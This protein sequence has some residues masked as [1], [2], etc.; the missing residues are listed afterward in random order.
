MSSAS[1]LLLVVSGSLFWASG[2]CTSSNPLQS[3]CS[4][5]A[6]CA[7]TNQ[8]VFSESECN[9]DAEYAWEKAKSAACT[10]V[11]K[12]YAECADALE[13]SCED[14]EAKEVGEECKKEAKEYA[15]C[16]QDS[17]EDEAKERKGSGNTGSSSGDTNT[18]SSSSSSGSTNTSSSSGSTS[19]AA[20]AYCDKVEECSNAQTGE[21]CRTN[22]AEAGTTCA[23]EMDDL[24]GCAA[25]LDC[26]DLAAYQTECKTE[27]DAYTACVN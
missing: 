9:E 11:L 4:R 25:A 12:E 8:W 24:L 17:L 10:G 15:E 27:N 23:S 13:L 18:S 6:E 2:G 22:Q 16:M 7:E 3:A 19:A 21:S 5:R 1:V 14:D 20:G 26:S